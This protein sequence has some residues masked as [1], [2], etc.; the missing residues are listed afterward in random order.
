MN[1]LIPHQHSCLLSACTSKGFINQQR[2]DILLEWSWSDKQTL[3]LFLGL[4]ILFDFKPYSGGTLRQQ[5]MWFFGTHISLPTIVS[6]C[7][8]KKILSFSSL[9]SFIHLAADVS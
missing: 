7:L 5:Q 6:R 8:Y 4:T 1:N 3:F 9:L 2:R